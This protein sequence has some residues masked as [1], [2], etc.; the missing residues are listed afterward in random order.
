VLPSAEKEALKHRQ[1]S[2]TSFP[3]DVINSATAAAAAAVGSKQRKSNNGSAF[4]HQGDDMLTRA[5][6]AVTCAM[7]ASNED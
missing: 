4:A 7:E 6:L 1:Q 2:A 3:N 5:T